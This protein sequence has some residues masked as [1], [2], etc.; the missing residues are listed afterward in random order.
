MWFDFF[1]Q[2]G[3]FHIP[4][5]LFA[6]LETVHALIGCRGIV[7]D[8]SI[9]AQNID[10][11]QF[12]T[13]ADLVVVIVMGR[14]NLDATGT[15]FRIDIVIGNNRN[16]PVT[17]GQF[18]HFANQVFIAFIVRVYRQSGITEHGFRAG[19]GNYH[20]I[21]SISSFC[22]L[23]KRI[24]EIPEG[25]IFFF[26]NN[27]QV[28]NRGM[29]FRVPVHQALAAIDQFFIVEADKHFGYSFGQPFIHGETFP[30]PVHGG[31]KPAHL[32]CNGITALFFPLPDF[33]DKLVTAQIMFTQAFP[34]QLSFNNHLGGN[35]GMVG[36][37]LPQGVFPQHALI[38]DHGIH[39][40]LLKTM[41]HMQAARDIGRRDHDAIGIALAGGPEIALVFPGLI[42]GGFDLLRLV[43][44]IHENTVAGK[45][46]HYT[47]LT[48]GPQVIRP[49]L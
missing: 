17:Q 12:M 39:N 22:A 10:Q 27:F 28:G 13:L 43:G 32:S 30:G 9:I 19:G 14:G 31:A 36:T 24:T 5:N 29:Q 41:P 49:D 45:A 2:T 35:T 25:A 44:F 8:C 15:K 4:D 7:V 26:I 23:G 33:I 21:F 18:H 20:M 42:P 34:L 1:Q 47:D 16:L 38:T 37:N 48:E 46:A 11:W 3:G 6:G 40:G